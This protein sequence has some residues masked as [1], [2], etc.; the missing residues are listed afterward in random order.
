MRPR[1][2]TKEVL[3]IRSDSIA[4]LA[5]ALA[6]AQGEIEGAVK[7]NVNPAFRSRYADLGA[8]WEAIRGPLSKRGIAVVQA[9][10]STETGVACETMLAHTSGEWLSEVFEVPVGK[11]DSHGFGSAATYARRYSLMGMVGLAPIDD[12]GNAA[13]EKPHAPMQAPSPWTPALQTAAA[14]AK[15]SGTYADWWK[16]QTEEFRSAAIATPEHAAFK[17]PAI[18]AAA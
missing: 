15:A 7:G 17:R 2:W 14:N 12:D 11:R 18:K 16:A 10:R 1:A 4:G 8:V 3:M 5:K 6:E 9:I 13:A